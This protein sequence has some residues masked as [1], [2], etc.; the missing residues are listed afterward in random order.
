[1][2]CL[3]ALKRLNGKAADARCG[4]KTK[5]G[6][7]LP[8]AEKVSFRKSAAC[9][10]DCKNS[11]PCLQSCLRSG[12]RSISW[13]SIVGVL[14]GQKGPQLFDR[15]DVSYPGRFCRR[16]RMGR[17]AQPLPLDEGGRTKAGNLLLGRSGDDGVDGVIDQDALGL[18]R[19]YIQA[20]ATQ[21][22]TTSALGRFG[23]FWK[24]RP[25]QGNEGPV[26]DHLDLLILGEGNGRIPQQTN[27]PERR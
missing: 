5:L 22:A 12:R 27:C 24:P 2:P 14:E 11:S 21:K 25:P 10:N 6:G 8:Y 26:C 13:A 3:A 20:S 9:R 17:S 4:S 16:V 15:F 1:M 23:V 7:C 18:D 19:V